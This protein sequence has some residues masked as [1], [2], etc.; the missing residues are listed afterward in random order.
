MDD[1]QY[2]EIDTVRIYKE[3]LDKFMAAHSDFIG[4]KLIYAP[5]R[6]IDDDGMAYFIKTCIEIKV[7]K[8]ILS[9]S[10]C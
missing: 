7:S 8:C 10:V 2:T 5:I 9:K 6:N 1:N 4:S 3:T